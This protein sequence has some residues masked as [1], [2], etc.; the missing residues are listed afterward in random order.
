SVSLKRSSIKPTHMTFTTFQQLSM[1]NSGW[2]ALFLLSMS[3]DPALL[4]NA[5]PQV[6]QQQQPDH[7]CVKIFSGA[8][9]SLDLK[10]ISLSPDNR[11]VVVHE[12]SKRK[13]TLQGWKLHLDSLELTDA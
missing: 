4:V 13:Y 1:F 6:P 10:S 12:G 8:F 9:D 2:L 3:M 7:L 11:T 5:I